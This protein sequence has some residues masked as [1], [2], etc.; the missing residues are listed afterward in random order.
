[1]YYTYKT[2][3]R[4]ISFLIFF[5][6]STIFFTH[7]QVGDVKENSRN[8]TRSN[9]SNDDNYS[10]SG[11]GVFLFFDVINFVPLMIDAHKSM[12]DRRDDE[13]WLV[14]IDANLNGGYY[15]NEST[16]IALPSI[17]GNWG[18]F[19]TQL[20]WN[21]IQDLTGA[22]KTF[23]WQIIQFNLVATPKVN[24]RLG[25]GISVL[26]DAGIDGDDVTVNE[27][28]AGLEL[29]FNDR[30]INPMLEF[31]W[32]RNY[33]TGSTP[34]FEM[35]VGSDFRIG[36][37]GKFDVNLMGGFLYQKYYSETNFYF[38]Q[39]GINLHFY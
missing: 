36:T 33:D 28:F 34:R 39:T 12:L 26:K 35:N 10:G 6:C 30:Q 23:D 8:D 38:I 1:M 18:L 9:R 2:H 32:S 19:S 27:H 29:H 17:R 3:I 24:F 31:R 13:P 25:T 4:K 14:S 15:T 5:L 16:S 20:R 11:S 7:A 21:R 22:F 37:F